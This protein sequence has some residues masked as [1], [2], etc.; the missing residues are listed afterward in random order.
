MIA[1]GQLLFA[2]L[3]FPGIGTALALGL[4][5]RVLRGRSH[6]LPRTIGSSREA[7]LALLSIGLAGIGLALMPWPIG[8]IPTLWIGAWLCFELAFLL[9]LLPALLHGDPQLARAAVRTAQLGSLARAI[10]WIALAATLSDPLVWSPLLLPFRLL[11]LGVALVA[12]LPAIGWGPFANASSVAPAGINAG[13]PESLRILLDNAQDVRSAALLAAIL[14]AGLPT[15]IG[16][17]WLGIGQVLAAFVV[18]V[19]IIQ[20]LDGRFPHLTLTRALRFSGLML[21]PLALI[22]VLLATFQ[23]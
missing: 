1:I 23:L 13:L 5:L 18:V 14:V 22:A 6:S 8:A 4:T 3:I 15:Q 21:T 7:L 16:S 10:I 20:R 12:L 19:L 17:A 9:P 2:A 11:A